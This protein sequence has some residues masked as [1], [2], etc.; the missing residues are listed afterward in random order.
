MNKK[1]KKIKVVLKHR[2]DPKDSVHIH[3][4]LSLVLGKEKILN[5]LNKKY[6]SNDSK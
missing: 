3:E 1:K 4:A 5:Y 6:K 2:P